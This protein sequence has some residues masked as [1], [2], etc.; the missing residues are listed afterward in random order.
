MTKWYDARTNAYMEWIFGNEHDIAAG[1]ATA[2]GLKPG[3]RVLDI[4]CNIGQITLHLAGEFGCDA[5]GIDASR[6][7]IETAQIRVQAKPLPRPVVFHLLDARAMPFD[8]GEFDAIVSK[9]TFVNIS[10]K[11]Q[12]LAELWRVLKPGAWLA[13]T[14]WMQGNSTATPALET[15]LE[16]KKAEP[17]DMVSLAGYRQLLQ[18]AGFSSIVLR[19]RGEEFRR[20][21]AGRYAELQAASP[22]DIR[23]YF[24]VADP[25]YF[26]KRFGLTHDVIMAWDVT[27]GQISA[28]K[29]GL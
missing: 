27:W 13:F 28:Q 21:I 1:L 23:D 15:W 22:T 9:D 29:P 7:A 19:D 5:I 6:A 4:G 12:L 8:E 14:D 2:A 16:F 10:P 26:V 17:F 18:E 11:T 3:M 25:E 20:H 24:G